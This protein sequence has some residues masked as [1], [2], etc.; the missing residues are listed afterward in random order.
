M[1]YSQFLLS[2]TFKRVKTKDLFGV[3][4]KITDELVL[5]ER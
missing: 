2:Q 5:K 3:F 4:G 1:V